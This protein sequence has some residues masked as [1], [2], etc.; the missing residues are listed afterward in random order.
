M[1][2]HPNRPRIT[3]A[4]AI[5]AALELSIVGSFSR[6]GSV[7]RSRLDGWTDPPAGAL[8]GRTALVT[9]P[10]SG[11]GRVT[12]GALADLGARVVLVGRDAERLD[13]VR[14]ALVERTGEDRFPVVRADLGSLASVREAVATI[15]ATEDR[16]D[17]LVDNAGAIFPER[18]FGPDGMESTFGLMVAG[19]FV[20]TAGL[21]PLLRSSG[22]R[23]IA[24]T[25]GG[26]YTQALDLED[27]QSERGPWSGAKAYARAKRAQTALVREWAR[28]FAGSAV[29]FVAMHPGWA[30]TPGLAA[31]L[32]GFH[33]FMGPLLRSADDG[34][35]TITWLA[36]HPEAAGRSGELF[37][38]RR[39][40]PFDRA[41][42]TRL[43]AVDRRRLWEAVVELTGEPDPASR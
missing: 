14:S 25:S 43:S 12:A 31:S 42:V 30:D 28:R 7:V 34:T 26:M 35:D 33:R 5:D 20:L 16:L 39:S 41:P 11:L 1:D 40:R 36:A 4:G 2:A 22:G 29:T 3:L 19:P 6:I 23:V 8:V 38:D 37:L 24:V 10:T 17:V 15:L 13:A 21:L 18:T 32:P 9:G 27:L